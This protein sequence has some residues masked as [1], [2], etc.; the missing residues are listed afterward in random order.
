PTAAPLWHL[1][2]AVD[3]TDA[4]AARAVELGGTVLSEPV[5]AGVVRMATLRD[6]QGLAFTVSRFDPS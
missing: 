3:D 1:T 6:P 2:F 4:V 5:D